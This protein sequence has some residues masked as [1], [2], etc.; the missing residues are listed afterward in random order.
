MLIA[1][2]A[3]MVI[4]GALGAGIASMITT[5]VRSSVDHSMSIQAIYLAESGVEWA[6]YQ[7]RKAYEESEKEDAWVD[8]CNAISEDP[9]LI[10]IHVGQSKYL[11]FLE[12]NVVYNDGNPI[13]CQIIVLGYVGHEDPNK[14]L[15]SRR[16][17]SIISGSGFIEN[18]GIYDDVV[19][20]EGETITDPDDLDIDKDGSIYVGSGTTVSIGE[21]LEIEN[22][23]SLYFGDNV[24]VEDNI[25]IKP[26]GY[27]YFGD[28]FNTKGSIEIKNDAC[29]GDDV[30]I[31]EDLI[32]ETAHTN[33]CI[34]DNLHVEG[35]VEIGNN[36]NVYIGLDP[37]V[38]DDWEFPQNYYVCTADPAPSG[39]D[40]SEGNIDCDE[41]ESTDCPDYSF[42]CEDLCDAPEPS[43]GQ[44]PTYGD[45]GSWSE[46]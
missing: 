8:K 29:F 30:N 22:H 34:G 5:G 20:G 1:V 15:A 38:D 26:Q 12:S 21:D 6:G 25:N 39:L 36:V 46:T 19:G 42:N 13:G 32:L 45:D 2:I 27:A 24:T 23:T 14:A 4:F 3:G 43:S 44:D 35:K 31:E 33:I 16:I 7:L 9:D 10:N 41:A 11:K 37:Q 17:N 40:C 18:G 28:E